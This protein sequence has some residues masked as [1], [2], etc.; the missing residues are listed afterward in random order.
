[1][2][3]AQRTQSAA[4]LLAMVE[5]AHDALRASFAAARDRWERS[6][7]GEEWSPRLNAEHVLGGEIRYAQIVAKA[8]GA[9]EP[10]PQTFSFASAEEATAALARLVDSLN[11]VYRALTD[12]NLSAPTPWRDHVRNVMEVVI[13]HAN[14]HAGQIRREH[15]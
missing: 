4:A 6:P 3:D 14:D 1:M 11:A 8:I 7:G 2:V 9:P 13:S 10:P 15:L 12:A 5:A